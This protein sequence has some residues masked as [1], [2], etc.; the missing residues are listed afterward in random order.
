V[1]FVDDDDVPFDD[2]VSY[3]VRAR[4]TSGAD[5]VA[6]GARFFRGDG[7]P[8]AGPCDVVRIPLGQPRELGLLSNQYGAQ[9]CLWS[10]DLLEQLGGFA[11]AR[12]I[13]EDWELLVRATLAGASIVGTPEPLWW[14]RQ[15][16]GGRY[17]T[18]PRANRRPAVRSVAHLAG[19]SLPD[20]FRLL[21]LLAAGGYD[22]LEDVVRLAKPRHRRLLSRAGLRVRR[23]REVRAQQGMSAVVRQ[24]LRSLSRGR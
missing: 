15:T 17:S 1:T 6:A 13:F 20:G 14:F 7:P 5:V 11:T 21:P 4:L 16:P 8:V 23:A 10:R 9:T 18:D 2:L 12:D 19:A 22:E 3:L 24:V